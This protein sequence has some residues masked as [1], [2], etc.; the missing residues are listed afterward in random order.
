VENVKQLQEKLA[1][2]GIRSYTEIIKTAKGQQTRVRAG[3][4]DSKAAAEKARQKLG[5]LGLK[6][7]AVTAR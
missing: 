7:A 3:P 4:F 2:A 1:G 6:P 5:E